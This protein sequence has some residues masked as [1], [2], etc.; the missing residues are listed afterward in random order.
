MVRMALDK[1]TITWMNAGLGRRQCKDQ[2]AFP[3]I[4]GCKAKHVAKKSAIRIGIAT[5]QKKM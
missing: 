2:P 5:V 1:L 3:R 4:D